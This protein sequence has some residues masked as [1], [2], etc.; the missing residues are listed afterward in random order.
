MPI[1][2]V[3]HRILSKSQLLHY[4]N[5]AYQDRR[6]D[7]TKTSLIKTFNLKIV[8]FLFLLF[9]GL[10]PS[11]W[12]KCWVWV[13]LGHVWKLAGK[14]PHFFQIRER[15]VTL[16]PKIAP[17]FLPLDFPWCIMKIRGMSK[18]GGKILFQFF[19]FYWIKFIGL[20]FYLGQVGLIGGKIVFCCCCFS[21]S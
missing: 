3:F 18:P 12:V 21:T 1:F 15:E 8:V 2:L 10:I 19:D 7:A 6:R 20:K 5:V 14:F 13:A 16:N 4:R 17:F 11:Y 9:M